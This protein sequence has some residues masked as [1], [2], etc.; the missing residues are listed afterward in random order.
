M[1]AFVRSALQQ[2]SYVEQQ[3][4]LRRSNRNNNTK[5]SKWSAG[6]LRLRE[7]VRAWHRRRRRLEV[8]ARKRRKANRSNAKIRR[9]HD[10]LRETK[11][12]PCCCCCQ[13]LTVVD[14]LLDQLQAVLAVAAAVLPIT[15]TTTDIERIAINQ[16]LSKRS[17]D[18][19]ISLCKFANLEKDFVSSSMIG[20]PCCCGIY[21]A[22]AT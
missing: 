17:F 12:P 11:R 3:S 9:V 8:C 19:S 5:R 10:V 7:I 2:I 6:V 18:R 21:S 14:A 20:L 1:L 4:D 15:K 16:N 13:F 22:H